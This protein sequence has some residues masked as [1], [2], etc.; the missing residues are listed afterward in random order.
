VKAKDGDFSTT[1]TNVP[2]YHEEAYMPPEDEVRAWLLIY[3]ASEANPDPAQFWKDLGK[4]IAEKS[5]GDMKPNDEV[6]QKAAALVAD[7]TTPEEKLTR[8]YDFCRTQIKNLSDD[9]SGL[10]DDDRAKLKDN[11]TPAD[12]LK[13]GQGTSGDIDLLFAAL[14]QA[15]GFDARIALM[16]DRSDV[17]FKPSFA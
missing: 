6:K 1:L 9:A 14:A 12:P 2:A 17:F 15:A 8:L 10:T 16:A 11:K 5:K 3:Y 13:R 4:R 7:A